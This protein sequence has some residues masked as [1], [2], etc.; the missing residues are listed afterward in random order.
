VQDTGWTAHLPHG[1]GLLPFTTLDEAEDALRRVDGDW[2]THA[3]AASEIARACFDADRVL[4]PLL[5]RACG[6]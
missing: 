6:T 2:E 1:T 5:E 4:P 3:R